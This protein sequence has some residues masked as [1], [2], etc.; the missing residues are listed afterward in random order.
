MQ[1]ISK[2]SFT[3]KPVNCSQFQITH[4][5]WGQRGQSQWNAK[6][7][8]ILLCLFFWPYSFLPQGLCICHSLLHK[9]MP[10]LSSSFPGTYIWVLLIIQMVEATEGAFINSASIYAINN[11]QYFVGIWN[12]GVNMSECHLCYICYLFAELILCSLFWEGS[13]IQV[14]HL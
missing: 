8:W 5:H 4:E 1:F 10:S 14:F 7:I 13:R 6:I 2:T 9:I 3:R 12:I 11:G